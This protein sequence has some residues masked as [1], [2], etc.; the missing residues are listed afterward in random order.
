MIEMIDWRTFPLI[1]SSKST[2]YLFFSIHFYLFLFIFFSV[3]LNEIF[4]KSSNRNNLSSKYNFE[5]LFQS[6]PHSLSYKNFNE[7]CIIYK[8]SLTPTLFFL[9]PL[10]I[11]FLYFFNQVRNKKKSKGK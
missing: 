7:S 10:T 6:S 3:I 4:Q 1:L 11:F 9:P 5:F 2:I 8:L